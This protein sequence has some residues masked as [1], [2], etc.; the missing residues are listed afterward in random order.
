MRSENELFLYRM[1]DDQKGL[2]RDETSMITKGFCS[3]ALALILID[4]VV[5]A[6]FVRTSQ[7]I[8]DIKSHS[9][10]VALDKAVTESRAMHSEFAQKGREINQNNNYE[11]KEMLSQVRESLEDIRDINPRTVDI[12]ALPKFITELQNYEKGKSDLR[13]VMGRFHELEKDHVQMNQS[14][15]PLDNLRREVLAAEKGVSE[16]IEAIQQNMDGYYKEL[17]SLA[18]AQHENQFLI[19]NGMRDSIHRFNVSF[20]EIE[21]NGRPVKLNGRFSF[22]FLDFDRDLVPFA[23]EF[24]KHTGAWMTKPTAIFNL[25]LPRIYFCTL[26]A[27]IISDREFAVRFEL[28]DVP[29]KKDSV[30]YSTS[31]AK[32]SYGKSAVVDEAFVF[33]LTEGEHRLALRIVA[34]GDA[35][36][37][38]VAQK[39]FECLSYRHFSKQ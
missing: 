21:R 13:S 8:T 36:M 32:G 23:F 38:S 37:V 34:A 10:A 31:N 22:E 39:H 24:G 7:R 33:A 6:F 15:R 16:K 11:L 25:R 19:Y 14:I 4:L 9:F 26:K 18:R 3:A 1:A 30:L 12:P 27:N 20:S 28:A 29:G 5:V 17:K 2:K 35:S